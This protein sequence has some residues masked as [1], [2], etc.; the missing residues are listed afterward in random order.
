MRTRAL[1]AIFYVK[2]AEKPS[3]FCAKK[4]IPQFAMDLPSRPHSSGGTVITDV[5]GISA[6]P[7]LH[8]LSA[9]TT[10]SAGAAC[11]PP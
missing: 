8:P 3:G 10:D 5:P 6:R 4:H 9:R 11:A 1:P 7:P 2:L